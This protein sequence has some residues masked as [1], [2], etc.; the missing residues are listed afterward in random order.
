M[1][2]LIL[3]HSVTNSQGTPSRAKS[4]AMVQVLFAIPALDKGGPDRVFF[5]LLR[6]VDRARVTPSLV[7]AE[8]TGH[9]LS[10]L[11]ADVA[12]YHLGKET[13]TATRYPILPLAQLVR[14][15]RPDVVIATLR[16]TFT[17]GLAQPLFPNET[18]LVL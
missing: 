8:P 17:A 11:P 18:R 2:T 6:K 10:K 15:L 1:H 16:M 12:V 13:S 3:G 5:E 7:T 9:Y 14:K 4:P